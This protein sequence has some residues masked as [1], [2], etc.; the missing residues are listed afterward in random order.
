[1]TYKIVKLF[2]T[3][4]M[5]ILIEDQDL[6]TIGKTIF[7]SAVTDIIVTQIYNN[8]LSQC[9]YLFAVVF[10]LE[11][12]FWVSIHSMSFHCFLQLHRN[13]LLRPFTSNVWC[14]PL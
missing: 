7:H 2:K 14:V 13:P 11:Q 5:S 8:D 9:S 10:F 4:C 1:M 12:E 6:F 3:K